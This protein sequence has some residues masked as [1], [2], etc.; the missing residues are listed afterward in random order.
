M[1]VQGNWLTQTN[2]ESGLKYF[3]DVYEMSVQE[4]IKDYCLDRFEVPQRAFVFMEPGD[5][6]VNGI[7]VLE[8][9]ERAVVYG[10]G[11]YDL[12][13]NTDGMAVLEVFNRHDQL[14]GQFVVENSPYELPEGDEEWENIESTGEQIIVKHSILNGLTADEVTFVQQL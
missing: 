9:G 1:I 13:F 14:V 3:E 4:L 7:Y 6:H 12:P 2:T 5:T 10:G 8:D 11:C